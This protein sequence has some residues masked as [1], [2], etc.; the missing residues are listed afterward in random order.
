MAEQHSS[1]KFEAGTGPAETGVPPSS[2]VSGGTKTSLRPGGRK[3]FLRA[4]GWVLGLMLLILVAGLF[5]WEH[6]RHLESTDDAQIDGHLHPI[7]ARVGGT[8]LK[9]LVQDNQ[10]VE[11]GTLLVQIDPKDFQVAVELARANLAEAEAN[12]HESQGVVPVTTTTTDSRLTGTQAGVLEAEAG[13]AS[14]QKSVEA[15]RARLASAQARVREARANEVKTERDLE[16]MKQLIAKEEISQQQFDAVVAAS[17]SIRAQVEAAESSVAEADQGVRLAESQL[18][19]QKARLARAQSE[20][21][22]AQTGPQ[23]VEISRH[24]AESSSAKVQQKKATLEQAELNLKYTTVVAPTSG[25]V[26]QRTVELG[27]VVQPGQPLLA[28]VP[29]AL[30][31]IWVTANF[32]ETQLNSMRP[33]QKVTI[34]V[35]AYGGKKY[36]GRV[37][38]IA[39]VTGSRASLLPPENATGNYVKVV[40]RVPVKIVFDQDQDP[41]HQLRPGMSVVPT[42]FTK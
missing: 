11:A 16:R 4:R 33:G 18:V 9:V 29:L 15:A 7:S 20:V 22:A 28:I 6:T 37:E 19:Q 39:A 8:V 34:Q 2:A 3:S 24:R 30:D 17:E 41:Q 36:S 23:Q 5:Y 10:Y 25:I 27:Q 32:K 38:S 42:V 31:Q 35:D 12:L 13:I 26:S 14:S 21:A 40:Q 1:Q